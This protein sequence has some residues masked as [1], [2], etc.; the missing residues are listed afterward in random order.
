MTE[1]PFPRLAEPLE[2]TSAVR[3]RN[4]LVF[5]PHYTALGTGDGV[6]S[7]RHAAYHA[8]RARGGAGL[9]IME[10]QAVHP[11]GKMNPHFVHAWDERTVPGYARVAE[12]VHRHGGK[13]FS[14]LT[15]GGHT[16]GMNPPPVLWA[17]TQMPEPNS[18]WAVKAMDA[19]DIAATVEGFRAGARN[20]VAG[21]VDGIEVKIAHDGL[22]R[23]FI[24]PHFNR[25][26]DAYGGSFENRMRMAS[27]V[28]TGIREEV[29]DGPALGVRLCLSEFTDWGYDLE[30]GLRIAEALESLGVLDYF[31]CDH[32]SWSSTWYEIPPEAI[33]EGAFRPLNQGLKAQTDLAVIA[34]GRIRRVELG[35]EML[36]AGE[37]DLI[38]MARQLIADPDVFEKAQRGRADEIRLCIACNATCV[39]QT[40][41]D[42]PIGCAVNPS[43]GRELRS[44]PLVRSADGTAHVLVI[45]GGP[46]GMQ[47]AI[48]L[49]LIGHHVTLVERELELGGGIRHARRQPVHREVGDCIDHQALMLE[50]LGVELQLG[51][52]LR[53]AEALDRGADAIIVAT[54][55]EPDLPSRPHQTWDHGELARALG[56]QIA[57]DYE[58][59]ASRILG[60]DECYGADAPS[61]GH[62]VVIDGTGHWESTGTAELLA[63]RGCRVTVATGAPR[64][65]E[66]LDPANHVLWHRRAREAGITLR[67][68]H[69]L[70]SVTPDGVR[71]RDVL[72]DSEVTVAAD[73][74]VPIF[75]RRSLE[76]LFLEL[77]RED[78]GP[79]LRRAGDC[80]SPRW[81]EQVI[82][83]GEDVGRSV[84]ALLARSSS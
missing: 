68:N 5:Q 14:Q 56:R 45:G 69:E 84:G 25:R 33:P 9:N 46:A 72:N 81:L 7:E 70:V 18:T 2:L 62:V 1:A 59:D 42:Q 80:V 75:A 76:D 35:E 73:H 58:A 10:S 22:L 20:A 63:A 24:S 31:N 11:S 47:A 23:T 8:A 78:G 79:I 53:A 19:D 64:I 48:A 82:R 60:S 66:H 29:G 15:H 37:A 28:L 51:H 52:E 41:Q 21:G 74:V 54:G 71:L 34:S 16:T 43:A 40:G 77:E 32:G 38:G 3:L 61:A 30:Y 13:V 65:G 67:P 44:P 27:E 12:A 17:P 36:A 6:P 50:R 4:R 57:P 49:A 26:T 83:E 39:Q 55:S